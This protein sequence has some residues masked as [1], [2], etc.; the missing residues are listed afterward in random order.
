M[1]DRTGQKRPWLFRGIRVTEALGLLTLIYGL[2]SSQWLVAIAGAGVL[3]AAYRIYRSRF[4]H[5]AAHDQGSMG[6][7]DGGD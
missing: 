2:A 7:S 4:P 5:T 6:M 1:K 3:I